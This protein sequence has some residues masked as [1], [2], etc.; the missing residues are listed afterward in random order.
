MEASAMPHLGQAASVAC[1]MASNLLA[2]VK[3]ERQIYENSMLEDDP[4]S[5][6]VVPSSSTEDRTVPRWGPNHKGAQELASLYSGSKRI[7]E[8]ICVIVSVVLMSLVFLFILVRIRLENLSLIMICTFLSM[9]STDFISGLAHW[10][11]DTWGSIELPII[12]KNFLRPFREHHI[13]PT[14]ITR[15]DFIETNGD[16]FAVTIPVLCKILYDLVVLPEP[17]IQRR[18]FWIC[19]WYQLTIFIAM[20]N[21][22]HKW[23][24]TYFG[25]PTFVVW[26]QEHRIILP[27][28]HHRVHHVAPHET[29]FCITTGWLNWPL[30]KLRFW[31]VL[32]CGIER[33]TGCKPR[34]DDMKWAQKRS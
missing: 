31:H 6:S 23:S 9:L 3:T 33:L 11:A 5:N 19:F 7:Q 17:E 10:A 30:E 28:R 22:I 27:R 29:Y 32:E 12:G 21:Q 1:T 18:F 4:N 24:H 8:V 16:T 20:T 13:D 26:L 15:H 34:A 25:L 2:P 14:S